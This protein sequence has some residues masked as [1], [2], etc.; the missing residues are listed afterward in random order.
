MSRGRA[1]A[2]LVIVAAVAYGFYRLFL[3]TSHLQ[4]AVVTPQMDAREAV[5]PSLAGHVNRLLR[6]RG[7]YGSRAGGQKLIALTFDD[8]PYPVFTPLLLDELNALKIPATFFL[9]GHDAQHWPQLTQRIER[10]GDEIANHTQTHPDLDLLSDAQVRNEIA[11][12]RA[13]L[14]AIV[15][16]PAVDT[17][18][19][20][21]HGRYTAATVLVAQ[22]LGYTTVL[23]NDD[24]GDWRSSQVTPQEL[25]QHLRRAA[26][27]PD[28]V[29]LHN[30]KL[31]TI[32]MLPA[33]AAA[34]RAAGYRF[35]T[36]GQLLRAVRADDVNHPARRPV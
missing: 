25:T 27:A 6:E 17:F 2:A 20:P 3:H 21:P 19:R 22:S 7:I 12:G 11:G 9:I 35:V 26:T 32:E 14:D 18:F 36:V 28:I 10:S 13:S 4:P 5:S 23:W 29:L 34:F 31:A 30:G 33:V 8:G 1:V 16:D 24:P 15:H